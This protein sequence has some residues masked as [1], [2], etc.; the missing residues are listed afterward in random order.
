MAAPRSA[1]DVVAA[2]LAAVP[3]PEEPLLQATVASPAS[4]GVYVNVL[5]D[6]TKPAVRVRRFGWVPAPATG[7]VVWLIR[8]GRTFICLGSLA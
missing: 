7:D 1:R 2:L 3:V 4:T 8:T 5:L 6:P